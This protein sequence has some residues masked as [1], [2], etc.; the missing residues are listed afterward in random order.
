MCPFKKKKKVFFYRQSIFWY[1][2]VSSLSPK[3]K[4]LSESKAKRAEGRREEEKNGEGGKKS[5]ARRA[6]GCK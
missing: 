2:S 6:A 1:S 4:E 5:K 3:H